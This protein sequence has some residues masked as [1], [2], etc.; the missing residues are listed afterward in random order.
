MKKSIIR[1][2]VF[3]LLA[4]ALAVPSGQAF[5]QEGKAKGKKDKAGA[6]KAEKAPGKSEFVP[7][8]GKI[9]AVD[10]TA[11]AVKV[12]ERTFQITSQTRITKAGKPATLDD[13]AVGEEVGGRYKK[14]DDGKLLLQ[15]LRIG[16]RP[17]GGEAKKEGDM[18][19]EG[20]K[21]GD[22]AKK[23]TTAQ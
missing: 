10:K 17:E 7:F 22:K 21:K 4:A 9:D 23:D 19:K 16:P 12:G 13:A 6:E 20:V 14:A 1:I 5:G 2:A 18:K 8:R 3:S 11:K 15:S